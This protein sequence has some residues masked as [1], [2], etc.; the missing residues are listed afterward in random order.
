MAH[1]QSQVLLGVGVGGEYPKEFEAIGVPVKE[2]GAR[3]DGAIAVMKRL[4]TEDNVTFDGRF[5]RFSGVT[6]Q[7]KPTQSGGP[8]IWIAGRSEAAIR[9][10]AAVRC[11]PSG[12]QFP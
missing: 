4:F 7:P 3:T 10:A 5:T 6:L 1:A 2:R 9:R 11:Q 12:V 8:P